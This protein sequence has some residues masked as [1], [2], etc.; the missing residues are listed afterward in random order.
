M[1]SIAFVLNRMIEQLMTTSVQDHA[2]M[3]VDRHSIRSLDAIQLAS[4]MIARD[5]MA[6]SAMLFIGSDG[7]LNEVARL[8]GFRVWNP[9]DEL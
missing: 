9:C 5:T 2:I 1:N 8:E 6:D 3:L 7:R 4:A